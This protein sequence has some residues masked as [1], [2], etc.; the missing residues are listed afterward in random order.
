MDK[1]KRPGTMIYFSDIK[2]ALNRMDD[3]QCGRLLRA[4]VWYAETGE[5]PELDGVEALVFDMLIP[6]IDRDGERYEESR[7]QRQYA[8][9]CRETKKKGEQPLT[10]SEWRLLR[11]SSSD[12]G[13]ISPDIGRYPST[14]TFATASTSAST[15]TTASAFTDAS[16]V[17]KGTAG[18]FRGEE[19][20]NQPP[21]SET[22][23]QRRARL[24]EELEGYEHG[25]I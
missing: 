23:D 15:T 12:N 14:S 7:E 19:G 18:G 16:T 17:G 6:K 1:S 8:V 2:P 5:Q 20:G 25:S 9:Y 11:L 10:I 3:A 13:P 22:L 24:I 21:P 4:I